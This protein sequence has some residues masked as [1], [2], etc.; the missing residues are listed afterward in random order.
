M[1]L[2]ENPALPF[3]HWLYFPISLRMHDL[4][5]FSEVGLMRII[6][7][8]IRSAGEYRVA[9]EDKISIYETFW[10]TLVKVQD[11][12]K[13]KMPRRPEK[14]PLHEALRCKGNQMQKY[15]SVTYD[16]H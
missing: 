5:P 1:D 6:L 3:L 11:M 14:Y 16:V 15:L 4:Y 9:L 12:G 10:R 8:S 7:K 13:R 2:R